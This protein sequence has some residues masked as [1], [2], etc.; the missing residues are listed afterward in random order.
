[1]KRLKL[2]CESYQVNLWKNEE[3]REQGIEVEEEFHQAVGRVVSCYYVKGARG[4]KLKLD[5]GHTRLI[6]SQIVMAQC[7]HHN[8]E[9]HKRPGERYHNTTCH[10]NSSLATM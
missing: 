3:E 10:I 4:G 7:H 6:I 2:T 5:L 8:N 1:M 9:C